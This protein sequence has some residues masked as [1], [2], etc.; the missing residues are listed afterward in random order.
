MLTR[1]EGERLADAIHRLRPDWRTSSLFTFI[2]RRKT[3]PYLDLALELVFVA[4]DP[5]TETPAR[6]DQDGPWK[7][8]ARVTGSDHG[9]PVIDFST[10][11][12]ECM[13]PPAHLWHGDTGTPNDHQFVA[14]PNGSAAPPV[15]YREGV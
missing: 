7:Q 14:P 5:R 10:A 6:I 11:C 4:L 1:V 9:I 2:E 15:D 13:K 3:R 8:L 12:H